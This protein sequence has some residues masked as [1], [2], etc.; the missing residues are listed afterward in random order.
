[1]SITVQDKARLLDRLSGS[2]RGTANGINARELAQGLDMT[3]REV[4]FAVTELRLEGIAVCGTPETGYFIA[5]TPEELEETCNFLRSRAMHSLTLESKLRNVPLPE[6][7]G[8]LRL[9][10]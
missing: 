1:M 3:L 5:T 7:L 8:Q 2:H 6:L 10:T 4:R 9:K